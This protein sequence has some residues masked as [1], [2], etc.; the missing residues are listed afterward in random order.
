[1]TLPKNL[2]KFSLALMEYL[3]G[4]VVGSFNIN[5]EKIDNAGHQIK[6]RVDTERQ[7]LNNEQRAEIRALSE[8]LVPTGYSVHFEF[9]PK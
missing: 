8:N 2:S 7:R 6:L 1:M 4:Q 5:D 3:R 9:F